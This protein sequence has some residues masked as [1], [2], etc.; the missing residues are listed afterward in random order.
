MFELYI[1][2]E[3]M[4]YSLLQSGICHSIRN[5][6]RSVS[7]VIYLSRAV[8]ISNI[9]NVVRFEVFAEVTMKNA[10]FWDVAPCRI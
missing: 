4:C 7:I 6:Y 8:Y 5:I 9:H 2:E 1:T 10:V 3:T